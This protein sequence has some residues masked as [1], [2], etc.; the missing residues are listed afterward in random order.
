MFSLLPLR[1]SP[2]GYRFAYVLARDTNPFAINENIFNSIAMKYQRCRPE[3]RIY[4]NFALAIITFIILATVL[5]VMSN[6]AIY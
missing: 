6:P 4:R 3:K 2:K 1:L 5:P